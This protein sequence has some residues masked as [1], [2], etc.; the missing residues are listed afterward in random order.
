MR[1]GEVYRLSGWLDE[2]AEFMYIGPDPNKPHKPQPS[3]W[4]W[5]MVVKTD[6]NNFQWL[7]RMVKINAD[8]VPL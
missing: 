4:V 1:F 6:Y 5:A 3:P 8:L 2:G 7:W